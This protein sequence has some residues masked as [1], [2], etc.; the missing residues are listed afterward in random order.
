VNL[1]FFIFFT[2][3]LVLGLFLVW[4]THRLSKKPEIGNAQILGQREAQNDYFATFISANGLLA[5]VA[6]GQ[7]V[8]QNGRQSAFLA[9]DICR[10]KF[11]Q[12]AAIED[13]E[14]FFQN[15]FRS[16]HKSIIDHTYDA[17]RAGT[18][19]VTALIQKNK[20]YW[21]ALGSC[22]IF[23]YRQKELIDLILIFQ[24]NHP[25]NHGN[26]P[27]LAA[28]E[29][30]LGQD[31]FPARFLAQGTLDLKAKDQILLCSDGIYKSISEIELIS[32]LAKRDNPYDKSQKIT[33]WISRNERDCQDNATIILIK[34]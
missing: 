3:I 13:K 18:A 8:H 20:L 6:D 7:G 22:K 2:S 26:Y 4:R 28:N 11:T 19:L 23:L 16:C 25:T 1:Y 10:R 9:V 33:D 15:T 31:I 24:K 12:A 30:K 29:Q 5:A 17:G 34:V 32:F 27:A 14:T 21:A